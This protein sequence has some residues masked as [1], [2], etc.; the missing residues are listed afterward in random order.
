MG[1]LTE[2]LT[3]RSEELVGVVANALMPS[4]T[5]F[6]TTLIEGGENAFG[7]I[8][9]GLKRMVAQLL[10]AVAVAALLTAILPAIG[11]G[12]IGGKAINIK[13][14]MPIVLGMPAFAEGGIVSGPTMGMIGE[15]AGARTNPEVIAPLDKLK[16]MLGDSGGG[17][18][19]LT[20]QL[21]GDDIL[22][23]VERAKNRRDRRTG[24][25]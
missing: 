16:S 11:I 17:N 24:F 6:F 7:A 4:F 5:Q 25:N 23:A 14:L 3:E 15:Y 1:D 19:N 18:Y 21:R 2:M 10:A 20:T 13:T 8:I 22:V 9:E 12:G